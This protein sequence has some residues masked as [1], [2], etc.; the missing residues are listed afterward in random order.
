MVEFSPQVS[1]EPAKPHSPKPDYSIVLGVK[2]QDSVMNLPEAERGSLMFA[3]DRINRRGRQ[4]EEI[5]ACSGMLALF[6]V[7]FP[8]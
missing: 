7:P 4:I 1:G 6:S 3:Y 2:W 5:Y 8:S